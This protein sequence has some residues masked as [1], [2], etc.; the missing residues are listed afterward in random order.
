[1][2]ESESDEKST[3]HET[4]TPGE[5]R[6]VVDHLSEADNVVLDKFADFP[7]G[8]GRASAVALGTSAIIFCTLGYVNSFGYA[9]DSKIQLRSVLFLSFISVYQTY[10]QEHQLKSTSP[11]TISWIGSLQGFFLFSGTV[12]GGPLFDRYGA[13]VRT[14]WLSELSCYCANNESPG[15]TNP[16]LFLHYLNHDDQHL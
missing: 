15:N 14:L 12:I 13:T 4:T 7:D 5:H 8:G 11:S 3:Q 6:A 9:Y 16:R 10:Y 2:A 1:M